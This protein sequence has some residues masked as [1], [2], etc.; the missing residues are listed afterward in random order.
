MHMFSVLYSVVLMSSILNCSLWSIY[1]YSQHI[2]AERK[3]LPFFGWHS[4]IFLH[5]SYCI[6]IEISLKLVLCGPINKIPALVQDNCLVPQVT[7]HYLNQWWHS[8]LMHICLTQPQWV[9]LWL[10]GTEANV[11]LKGMVWNG[12]VWSQL[13]ANHNQTQTI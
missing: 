7:S 8:L 13:L 11:W 1:Q 9:K 3:W 5:E 12:M 10:I 2:E 6:L 4:Q